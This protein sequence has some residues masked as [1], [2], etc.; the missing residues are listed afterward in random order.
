MNS[1]PTGLDYDH[2]GARGCEGAG[3][4]MQT[5]VDERDGIHQS[6]HQFEVS[7]GMAYSSLFEGRGPDNLAGESV[8]QVLRGE[9]E[10]GRPVPVKMAP[11]VG[12]TTSFP[13][14][15]ERKDLPE[16]VVRGMPEPFE[17]SGA[18]APWAFRQ[19]QRLELTGGSE[20]LVSPLAARDSSCRP[21]ERQFP[22]RTA[23]DVC[24]Q[25]DQNDDLFIA[26]ASY[27][28]DDG[29]YSPEVVNFLLD[30][31][32]MD[33]YEG[34]TLSAASSRPASL[35]STSSSV[36]PSANA[37]TKVQPPGAMTQCCRLEDSQ[38]TQLPSPGQQQRIDETMR[39]MPIPVE[40]QA[41]SPYV[42]TVAD[43]HHE[44]T[45]DAEVNFKRSSAVNE[46]KP[47]ADKSR[48]T[49]RQKGAELRK[50]ERYRETSPEYRRRKERR[51][52]GNE[53]SDRDSPS[54]DDDS[55]DDESGSSGRPR[56][57]FSGKR[58]HRGS[59]ASSD[60]HGRRSERYAISRRKRGKDCGPS[61]DSEDSTL[62][63]RRHRRR[64]SRKRGSYH[65]EIK[66]GTY[67]GSTCVESFILHFTTV[68]DYNGWN[69]NDRAAHLKV[70]LRGGP[71]QLLWDSEHATYKE[72]VKKLRQ[73]YG[74]AELQEK[75]R[76]ELK[77]QRRKDGES[78]Q[79]L[80]DD[81]ERLVN[82][83]NP[84]MRRDTRDVVARDA[85]L[86]VE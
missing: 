15:V 47:G 72:I 81:V 21:Y 76:T 14:C 19:R 62:P 85:F 59:D 23:E 86:F 16:T 60:R 17:A 46:Y 80:A 43:V 48:R 73:R 70:A 40:R 33:T 64:S 50:E 66:I 24:R 63:Q 31:K 22:P 5:E 3:A 18:F 37:V 41:I 8:G 1:P 29:N 10:G 61:Y 84:K 83:A 20:L 51:S 68:A 54:D 67:D 9:Q 34:T 13:V 25:R 82:L 7:T 36:R 27:R 28:R 69:Q 74:N 45:P 6:F 55:D 52:Y 26:L 57:R 77:S 2:S 32:K 53:P 56:R 35:A 78:L 44:F 12:Q 42:A 4:S 49:H 71:E 39:N 58:R 65:R 79:K 30:L 75:Y 11:N 38:L